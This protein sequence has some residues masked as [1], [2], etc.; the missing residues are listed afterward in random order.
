[1]PGSPKIEHKEI[2]VI[3]GIKG[4]TIDDYVKAIGAGID[5]L[6]CE[7]TRIDSD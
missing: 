3:H 7:G 4:T 2:L 1:M 5:I 6:I